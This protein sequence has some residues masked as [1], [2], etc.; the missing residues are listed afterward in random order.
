MFIVRVLAV[1]ADEACMDEKG[2]FDLNQAHPMVYFH[3]EYYGLGKKLGTFGYS[4]KKKNKKKT[5][6]K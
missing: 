2:R 3:G 4:V 5:I 6:K 1:H